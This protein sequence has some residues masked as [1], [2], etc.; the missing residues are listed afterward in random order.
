MN[1]ATRALGSIVEQL[2]AGREENDLLELLNEG[3]ARNPE[4]VEALRLLVRVYWW[5]RD[6]E[7][8]RLTLERLAEAA[9][10]GGLVEDERYALTQLI[11]LTPNERYSE[12]LI[13]L[14]GSPDEPGDIAGLGT[15]T[16][17]ADTPIFDNFAITSQETGTLPGV[18]ETVAAAEFE[19]NSVEEQ[20]PQDPSASF[21][22][23]NEDNE[24]TNVFR[25]GNELTSEEQ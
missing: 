8:L 6:M 17:V 24:E 12:R 13:A 5:Q 20:G 18:E 4:H 1:D 23:L 7:N 16:A 25:R 21:A 15:G 3:L 9:E 10:A 14:G 2:L 19:W 11:R 22:D